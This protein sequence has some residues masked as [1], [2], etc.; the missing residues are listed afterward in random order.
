MAPTEPMLKM[1]QTSCTDL[2]TAA[3]NWKNLNA[4]DLVTLNAVLAKANAPVLAAVSPAL[5]AP[6]CAP[7]TSPKV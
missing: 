1:F 3:T 6:A 7:V 2:R 5:T 4:Q